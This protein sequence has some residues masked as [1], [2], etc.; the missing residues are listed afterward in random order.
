MF[1]VDDSK[2]PAR[3][4]TVRHFMAR[5]S[6]P[7]TLSRAEFEA[8]AE[9]LQKACCTLL[10]AKGRAVFQLECTVE[11][12][13][14]PPVNRTD[15][16]RVYGRYPVDGDALDAKM[17]ADLNDDRQLVFLADSAAAAAAAP[18]ENWH[19]QCSMYSTDKDRPEH[20]GQLFQC[21][22][23]F[24]FK[25]IHFQPA[26]TAGR[27]WLDNYSSKASTR[28]AGPWAVKNGK[29][30]RI[31]EVYAG[32]DIISYDKLWPFQKAVVDSIRGPIHNRHIFWVVNPRGCS[33]KTELVKFL[34]KDEKSD[35][36]GLGYGS[37]NDLNNLIMKNAGRRAYVFDLPRTR[38][39]TQQESDI[40]SLME[41]LKD[42]RVINLKY[43]TQAVQFKS[44][45]VWVFANHMPDL[46]ALTA[47]RL[48]IREIV[49]DR[50]HAVLEDFD[51][52]A[53]EKRQADA[54]VTAMFEKLKA[55]AIKEEEE[56]HAKELFARWKAERVAPSNAEYVGRPA[57]VPLNYMIDNHLFANPSEEPGLHHVRV[58]PEPPVSPVLLESPLSR[59][60]RSQYIDDSASVDD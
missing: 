4:S 48:L 53:H 49:G 12:V 27:A 22:D 59:K 2:A 55:K 44:P 30:D 7:D 39:G 19:Y 31:R 60:R 8:A 29:P 51:I 10:G 24:P 33:G 36:F 41:K 11:Q 6:K 17:L 35:A 1:F 42:G 23:P 32:D 58:E 18:K 57:D 52:K 15:F 26:S 21:S 3:A 38:P 34:E 46:R 13:G 43:E 25:G 5:W 20:L 28:K 50:E 9:Q 54:R 47:D 40:Y 37:A 16:N 14:P 45:H 56:A